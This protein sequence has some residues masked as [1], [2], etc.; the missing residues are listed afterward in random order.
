MSIR[1]DNAIKRELLYREHM[2]KIVSARAS[3]ASSWTFLK[4]SRSDSG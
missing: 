2:A 4:L 1:G 3:H